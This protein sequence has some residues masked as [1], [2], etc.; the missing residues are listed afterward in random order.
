MLFLDLP[1]ILSEDYCGFLDPREKVW[2]GESGKGYYLKNLVHGC[3]Q[4]L[5]PF[6]GIF[7]FSKRVPQ[8]TGQTLF[9]F[10]LRNKASALS[11]EIYTVQK[12]EKLLELL[13]EEAQYLL[14][15]L[16]SVCAIEV[17]RITEKNETLPI[18]SVSVSQKD[19]QTRSS[20]Q[21]QLLAQVK[22]TFSSSYPHEIIMDSS[23]FTLEVVVNGS[24]ASEHELLV[25]NQVGSEDN[26]VMRLAEKQHVLPWVGTAVELAPS[27]SSGR[28]FCVLP[29]P[30]EDR[31]PF[32]VHVNGTFAVSSNRRSLK[33]EAQERKGDEESTWNKL[34]IEKCIP[35][36]Y[37][38]LITELMELPNIDPSTVYSC[39]PVLQKVNDTSWNG[40]LEPFYELLLYNDKAV[41]CVL[42]DSQW[43]S[44]ED[45]VI[46]PDDE[47]VYPIIKQVVLNCGVN[48]VELESNQ[49]IALNEYYDENI[50]H[51][52]PSKVRK[53]L[54]KK[55][56]AYD[57][58]SAHDKMVI[59]QYCLAD[60]CVYA[61]LIGL[62]LL[63]LA[64]GFF[65]TFAKINRSP[66]Q[67]LYVYI[68]S[69]A[70][71]VS[72]L[73]DVKHKLINVHNRYPNIHR[74]LIRISKHDYSMV[75]QLTPGVVSNLLL[76]CKTNE[77]SSK[78]MK[79]FW[80][81]LQDKDLSNFQSRKIVPTKHHATNS[82]NI[83]PLVK[84][85]GCSLR[86]SKYTSAIIACDWL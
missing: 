52:T 77:W 58:L 39:W 63:P 73:P 36:C 12:L 2:K 6:D 83:V 42:E 5:E 40:L 23:R 7:G 17:Y 64:N 45:S 43:I 82:V 34:L 47:A 54:K 11:S 66:S 48:L 85:N 30:I 61:N 37:F 81:W 56:S 50:Q 51:L 4:A 28:V 53:T 19:Y 14:I 24:I 26:E 38:T 80:N 31:T 84:G 41:H 75:K 27:D 22:S 59:L 65:K 8:Y 9:R 68:C 71:P 62:E 15:F 86:I 78:Q 10:P 29:L 3:S 70:A 60:N 32:V 33:W 74:N 67:S 69:P 49:H 57:Q 44:I 25:V 76:K 46:I 16:R 20:N 13:N 21:K 18:F 79:L 1:T 55:L 72:L 35:D